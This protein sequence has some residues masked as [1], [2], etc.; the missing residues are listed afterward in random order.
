MLYDYVN[1]KWTPIAGTAA[2][3]SDKSVIDKDTDNKDTN[4]VTPS[5]P[6][7]MDN[8]YTKEEVN[9]LLAE[10]TDPLFKDSVAYTITTTDIQRWNNNTNNIGTITGIVMNGVSVGVSGVVN[11]GTVITEHQSLANYYTK[12]EVEDLLSNQVVP[13]PE[14]PI[15]HGSFAEAVTAASLAGNTIFQWL[16]EEEDSQG[17]EVKK[18]IWH[19]GNGG[20]I[21]AL[22]SIITVSNG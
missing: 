8:Y 22:G 10:E 12:S 4:P 13:V 9:N 7:N 20:F 11:L 15:G 16:L 17:N 5:S 21:D 1:G 6:V 14:S 2:N 3:I 18:I 19:D